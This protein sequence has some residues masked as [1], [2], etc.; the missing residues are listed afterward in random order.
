MVVIGWA[1]VALTAVD[2][3]PTRERLDTLGRRIV[4]LG[5]YVALVAILQSR[6][7]YDLSRFSLPGLA[8]QGDSASTYDIRSG[9]ERI[10]S[11]TLHPIELAAVLGVL[12]PLALHYLVHAQSKTQR[13]AMAVCTG[14]IAVAMPMAVT[15]TGVLTFGV[16]LLV[17]IPAWPRAWRR[18][19]YLIGVPGVL[20]LRL[21]IPGLLGTLKSLFLSASEDPSINGRTDDFPFVFDLIG[22]NPVF[23]IGPGTFSP[24]KYF[25][26]DNQF[27]GTT[28]ELGAVG[29]I[30]MIA[31]FLGAPVVAGRAAA[32]SGIE[33][34]RMLARALSAGILAC[35]ATFFTFDT[36]GFP[37]ISGLLFLYVGMVGALYRL[38]FGM[39]RP[40]E[41]TRKAKNGGFGGAAEKA[42]GNDQRGNDER[43]QVERAGAPIVPVGE[44]KALLVASIGGHL[45][46]LHQLRTRLVNG[47]VVWA[48]NDS[49]QSRSLLDGEVVAWMPYVAPRDLL[50]ALRL[51]PEAR[52]M[53]RQPEID[54]VI[55]TGSA[56]AVPFLVAAAMRGLPAF[57]IESATRAD[58]PSMTGRIL[59]AVPGVQLR[60]QSPI[61]ASRRWQY[62]GSV[63]DDWVSVPVPGSS[64]RKVV[65]SLGTMKRYEFRSLVDQL[66]RILPSDVDVLWQ[67]GVTDVSDLPIDARSTVSAAEMSAA[68]QAA[69]V[70]VAHAGTGIA[71]TALAAGKCPVLVPRRASRSEHVDDHQLQTARRLQNAQLA[72][73][74]EVEELT[75]AD[76]EKAATLR[77]LLTENPPL[78]NLLG[79]KP[80][81][82]EGD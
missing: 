43:G 49:P 82:T 34:D 1:G 7:V 31:L 44:R 24:T 71:L 4:Y 46:Q 61:W 67:V 2:G 73:V 57:Y 42:N 6:K 80:Q 55:S 66:L 60:T 37:V 3:T 30:C 56:V 27:L 14:L 40:P 17:L 13:R 35:F 45:T 33:E 39:V 10:K 28:V 19:F 76:L 8:I 26:L 81:L 74:S 77:P 65:V 53:V 5:S 38:N 11:T 23:G 50:T 16:A 36:L 47:D 79:A 21:A 70:V 12:L 58:G 32:M 29:A 59:S 64:I 22:R 78:M 15:R 63:F 72:V 25:F 41:R 9:F 18:R 54:V 51:I 48:T 75:W 69:D 20:A 52:R 62:A 68:M